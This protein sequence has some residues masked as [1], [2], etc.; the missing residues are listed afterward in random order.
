[1]NF[2]QQIASGLSRAF[3]LPHAERQQVNAAL[4]ANPA[5]LT[6]V[7]SLKDSL[8]ATLVHQAAGSHTDPLAAALEA[9]VISSQIERMIPTP[10][11]PEPASAA[12]P[13]ASPVGAMLGQLVNSMEPSAP[14]AAPSEVTPPPS[15]PPAVA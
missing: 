1:M 3:T 9:V 13:A 15:P 8:T 6:M 4:A 2:F 10:P 14:P 11:S 7:N 12:V 5:L